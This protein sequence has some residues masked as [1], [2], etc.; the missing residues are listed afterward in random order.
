MICWLKV[1]TKNIIFSWSVILL[2]NINIIKFI[3][4]IKSLFFRW[5]LLWALL[6][7]LFKSLKFPLLKPLFQCIRLIHKTTFDDLEGL[8]FTLLQFIQIFLVLSFPCELNNDILIFVNFFIQEHHSDH[9]LILFI[10]DGMLY[11]SISVAWDLIVAWN[12]IHSIIKFIE[13]WFFPFFTRD[14]YQ[15]VFLNFTL[16]SYFF[17]FWNIEWFFVIKSSAFKVFKVIWVLAW[18]IIAFFVFKF[19]ILKSFTH[20]ELKISYRW[21][22]LHLSHTWTLTLWDDSNLIVL[23]ETLIDIVFLFHFQRIR[24]R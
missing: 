18:L 1:W 5:F 22:I 3:L 15:F 2:I 23:K 14:I 11:L 8:L 17:F 4:I 13:L 16:F 19:I 24:I 6:I 10:R 12:Q 21:A 7:P 9:I 20:F